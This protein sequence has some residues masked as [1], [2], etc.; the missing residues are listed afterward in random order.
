MK[1][2]QPVGTEENTFEDREKSKLLAFLEIPDFQDSDA[3]LKTNAFAVKSSSKHKK[4]SIETL[5]GGI[6]LLR[7]MSSNIEIKQM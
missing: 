6:K 1:E 7:N 4:F 3:S 2:I 5:V